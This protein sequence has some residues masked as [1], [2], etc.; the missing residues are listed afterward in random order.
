MEGNIHSLEP[1]KIL[2]LSFL[3][4]HCV[5]ISWYVHGCS[6]FFIDLVGKTLLICSVFLSSN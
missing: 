6:G 5:D 2:S 1:K 4:H 3:P